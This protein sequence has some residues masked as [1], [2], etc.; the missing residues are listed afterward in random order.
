MDTP[1]YREFEIHVSNFKQS[2]NGERRFN[3]EVTRSPAGE[4]DPVKRK[5]PIDLTFLLGKLERRKLDIPAL[6]ALGEALADLLLPDS[7]RDLFVRSLDKLEKDQGLRLRLRLPADL[8][9][10]PWEFMYI[11]RAGDEQE[12]D[13]DVTGFLGL[14]PRVSIVRHERLPASGDFDLTPRPRRILAAL[15]SPKTGFEQLDLDSEKSKLSAALQDVTGLTL[16]VWEH[17]QAT[18]LADQLATA[19]DIFHFAG[20]GDFNA[21]LA[22]GGLAVEGEGALIF[23][24]SSQEAVPMPAEQ[25]ATNLSGRGLQLVVLGACLTGKRDGQNRWS[26]VVAALM[27]V[28]IPAAVTMQYKIS[29]RAAIRFMTSFYT[30]LAAGQ[31]LDRA[32]STARLAVFNDLHSLRDHPELWPLWR[33][34]GVPVLYLRADQEFRLTT[35]TDEDERRKAEQ[36]LNISIK[37]RIDVIGPHGVYKGVEAGVIQSGTIEAYLKAKEIAGQVIQVEADS[38]EGGDI[39]VEGEAELVNGVW[40]ALKAKNIGGPTTAPAQP[41]PSQPAPDPTPPPAGQPAEIPCPNC[42]TPNQAGAKFCSNCGKELKKAPRF[43]ANCGSELPA[44]AKFCNN[45][46]TKVT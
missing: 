2:A 10:I 25:F 13:K 45:C 12:S 39:H 6:I 35:I 5:I 14:D 18:D 17:A 23:E 31:P 33:D 42:G 1:A 4:G 15:S 16:D 22:P 41:A 37:H 43:C 20:H 34:W 21:D 24:G 27:E 29:D 19:T 8:A 30:A 9:D 36:S 40:I 26:G 32:V 46:G 11:S 38:I 3:V 28:G 7:L 44:G